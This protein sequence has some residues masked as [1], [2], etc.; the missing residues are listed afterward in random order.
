MSAHRFFATAPKGI[1]PL[2]ADE[3]RQLGAEDIVERA[4]GAAFT[5][6][7]A[8]GYRACLWSRTASRVLLELARFEAPAPEALYTGVQTIDWPEH[9]APAGTLAVDF[10]SQRS[11]ITHTHFG[12]LK[13][14]DA[15]VDQ[16]RARHG[17]RPSVALEQPDVRISVVLDRDQAI[18]SLDLSGEGLHR[19][20]YRTDSVAAAL[21]QNLAAALLL[22]CGWP[23]IAAASGAFVD[24]MCGSGT[25]GIEAAMI[26]G[27]I[28]PG[29]RRRYYGFL[30]WRQFD[31]ALWETLLREAEERRVAGEARLPGVYLSDAD[32]RAIAA[33]KQN[34]K[35]T[36][37]FDSEK[38]YRI[39]IKQ[40]ELRELQR[41]SADT[42]LVLVNPPYGERLGETAELRALYTHLG[43][44][45]R[46]EFNGWRAAVFTGNP[47]LGKYLGLTA[48]RKHTFYNGAIECQL[49]RF[50]ITPGS[51]PPT[52]DERATR[53][54]ERPRSPGAQM[55]TNRLEKNLDTVGRWAAKEDI[56]CYRLYDADM[57]EYAL[58]IDLY[59]DESG[60]RWAHAQE[61]AAPSTVDRDKARQRLRDALHVLPEVLA[62]PRERI[63]LKKRERK[64]G[65]AQYEKRG[66]AGQFH[67][68]REGLCRLLVNFEDYLDTGLF[69]DHRITRQMIA[70]WARDKRFLNLFAYTATATVHAGLSGVRA[71]TSVDLSPTYLDWA[72]RN[73]ALNGLN[74]K[75]HELVQADCREWLRT[76]SRDPRRRYDLIFLD[77]PTFSNS[78]R[79]D[80][81]LDIQ[82]DHVALIR[83][84]LALLVPGGTLLFSTN[85]QKFK[86]DTAA[87]S[88]VVIED[89][90]HASLPRDFARNPHIHQCFKL[91]QNQ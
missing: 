45:L 36:G 16:F 79:M 6:D 47:P 13:V 9:L 33:A 51:V 91:V 59:H 83:D 38:G 77:P 18:L 57:P 20:G 43:E 21:K 54:A 2:L 34:V 66:E 17:E 71:T 19:R 46:Q 10:H 15:I 4:A 7:S 61:Y 50:D 69:L 78:K 26:A 86:L 22:R 39:L 53:A 23:A 5:G 55:F 62:I 87:L 35:E 37:L 27:D 56:T 72:G 74:L 48:K 80:G 8:L 52:A 25:L 88:G 28:A 60:I 76:Q 89:I 73:L 30:R 24:P 31:T 90:G 41:P 65:K 63:F 44:M 64:P 40:A 68:V 75:A 70:A 3:L 14:K 82:R 42:G 58:A 49:L 84:T 85:R 11:Q 32:P 81:T 67:V 12:A 1:A 29:L